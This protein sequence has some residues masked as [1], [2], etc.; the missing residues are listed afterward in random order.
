VGVT[1]RAGDCPLRD[2]E[3]NALTREDTAVQG[4]P[5]SIRVAIAVCVPAA[6][7]VKVSGVILP[8]T[9]FPYGLT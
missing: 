2:G 1:A 6:T 8:L 3:V 4:L 5:A 7:L 9:A